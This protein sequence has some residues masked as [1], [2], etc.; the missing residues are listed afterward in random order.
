MSL[1]DYLTNFKEIISNLETIE[2][3]YDEKDLRLILLC[4]L[5]FFF[6]E[7]KNTIVH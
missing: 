5:P 2:G 3:K 1:E 4:S 7:F 6:C